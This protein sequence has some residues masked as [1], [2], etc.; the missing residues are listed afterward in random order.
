MFDKITSFEQLVKAFYKARRGKR[1]RIGVAQYEYFLEKNI[2]KLQNYLL[3]GK[4]YPQQYSHFTIFEP[5]TR[6]ISAPAFTDRIVQHSIVSQIE[7]I[8]E[9]Q[10]IFDSYACRKHKGTHFGAQRIK[11]FLMAAR[12]IYGK[13]AELY[14]MQCDIHKYFHSID[15]DILLSILQR[16]IHCEKTYE[17]IRRIV[18]THKSNAN[19]SFQEKAKNTSQAKST[20]SKPEQLALFE[21]SHTDP[22]NNQDTTTISAQQRKGLP[23]GNL[24]SQLFANIYLNEL[25]QYVKHSLKQ[26]WYARYMDDFLIIH[27]DRKKLKQLEKIIQEFLESKLGLKLHPKKN[28]IKNVRDGV[29]FVG[30]RI[31]YDHILVRGDTLRH[32][33]R[34]YRKRQKQFRNGYISEL[35]LSQSKAAIKGH[36]DHANA[37]L[38]YHKLIDVDDDLS[39]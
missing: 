14:V 22:V 10:F 24:T 8:F 16:T 31:F 39:E 36:L 7:P 2:L 5:K 6:N 17:L 30:Y 25:D 19:Q 33:Q 9:K 23:I 12:C 37:Y 11:K 32:M 13:E 4:Y 34:K 28:T 18:V 21:T 38:L 20:N 35:D 15:W 26:R 1:D 29:P 3:S 27:H